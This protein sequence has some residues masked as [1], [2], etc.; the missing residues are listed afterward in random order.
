MVAENQDFFIPGSAYELSSGSVS[1]QLSK[2]LVEFVS[3]FSISFTPDIEIDP[4]EGC[5]VKY[6]FPPEIDAQSMDLEEIVA[7]GMFVDASGQS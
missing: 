5:W 2:P 7:K 6:T 4:S 1:I 3:N